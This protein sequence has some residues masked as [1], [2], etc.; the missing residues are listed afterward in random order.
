MHAH[1]IAWFTT[2]VFLA[3]VMYRKII[4]PTWV[5]GLAALMFVLDSNTYLPV[6]FVANRGVIIAL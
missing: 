5:A 3:T 6:M 4:G 2:I 1:N